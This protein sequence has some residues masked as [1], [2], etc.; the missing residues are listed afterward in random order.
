M[1][2]VL[3]AFKNLQRIR[4]HGSRDEGGGA[5]RTC[6]RSGAGEAGT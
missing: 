1:L 6:G 4:E 3:W 2:S 5:S